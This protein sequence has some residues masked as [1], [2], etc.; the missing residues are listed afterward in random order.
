MKLTKRLEILLFFNIAHAI[1]VAGAKQPHF[2]F[3]LGRRAG[4]GA[5]CEDR[6]S[7]HQHGQKANGREKGSSHNSPQ[8]KRFSFM[9]TDPA[10]RFKT[11]A[12]L[13]PESF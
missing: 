12:C 11:R 10:R 1:K 2:N 8:R 7:Q 9:K 6:Q 3:F 5:L 13:T 4:R